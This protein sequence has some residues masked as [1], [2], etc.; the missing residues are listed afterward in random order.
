MQKEI[1]MGDRLV[2]DGHPCYLVGE[3]GINH[4]GSLDLAEDLISVAKNAGCDAVKFQKRTIEI[5][6][7][8]EELAKPRE[9][10]FGPTN[11]DLKRG[12]EFGME[13]Y[14]RI[15]EFCRELEIPWF[16]SCWDE[17]SVDFI[18]QFNVPCFKIASAS[19]TDDA[20]VRRTRATGKPIL[21]STGMSAL[22][23]ID[24]AVEILGT[25]DLVVLHATSTYPRITMRSTCGSSR[26]SASATVCPSVTPG[27]RPA[28]RLR[29]SGCARRLR[30]R[31]TYT[32]ELRCGI[33]PGASLGPSGISRLAR[34]IRLVE[35]AL[36]SS[37]K[38]VFDRDSIMKSSP[39]RLQGVKPEIKAVAL[40][41][42]GVLTDGTFCGCAWR[43]TEAVLISRCDGHR[44]RDTRGHNL[45]A[46]LR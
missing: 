14:R 28:S 44:A 35:M 13:Q 33:R 37:T 15:D 10:P 27:T 19:L 16:A 6:Y 22:E 30:G 5:V 40:D 12:L 43:G 26:N 18:A 9:N 25:K 29:R 8:P 21:L 46:N 7:T 38:R 20:L 42:D 24:H 39:R 17:P 11:G 45:R 41:V 1:R 36:G 3:I 2:G 34:D 32:L 31:A 23:E 4:N